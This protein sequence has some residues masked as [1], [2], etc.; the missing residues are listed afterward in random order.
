MSR[1]DIF[2]LLSF[3]SV[4]T[5]AL[6]ATA[7]QRQQATGRTP[8]PVAPS[9]ACANLP[10]I[11]EDVPPTTT[12]TDGQ[13]VPA[14]APQSSAD[15]SQRY[16]RCALD[17][18]SRQ[19]Y[20][21]SIRHFELAHRAAPSADL[22]YNIARSHELLNEYV[23]AADSYEHYLRDKVNAPDRTELEAHIRELRDLDRRRREAATRQNAPTLLRIQVDRPGAELRLDDRPIGVSP[24]A[25]PVELA[26]GV[27]ILSAQ[28][29]GSQIWRGEVRARQG[30]TANA[31]VGLLPSTTFR[32]RPPTH[33][34]SYVI[35]G[36][37]LAT[38]GTSVVL[39][40]LGATTMAG[41][42]PPMCMRAE[43]MAPAT[44]GY[45]SCG[46]PMQEQLTAIDCASNSNSP[47]CRGE[48]TTQLSAIVGGV[49]VAVLTGAIIAYFIESGSR[50]TE[51]VQQTR[52]ASW[53][54]GYRRDFQ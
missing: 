53:R 20:R 21:D 51:E 49:G 41:S 48:A 36:V 24:L 26:T 10:T 23:E 12:G 16:L 25:S 9:A 28:A 14:V 50:R 46:P 7:Q 35:G 6:T 4:T 34:L 42:V 22:L 5:L 32:T 45:V 13:P 8:Q 18:F 27:H 15:T 19:Q 17:E 38:L 39:G 3:V 31:M 29:S 40:I 30:E 54:R 47:F 43:P 11:Q 33:V 52:T 44:A 2:R 37:G 1:V